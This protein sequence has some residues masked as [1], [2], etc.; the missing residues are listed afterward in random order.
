MRKGLLVTLTL[1]I[2]I[3]AAS[4]GVL[5]DSVVKKIQLKNRLIEAQKTELIILDSCLTAT[6]RAYLRQASAWN[7]RVMQLVNEIDSLKA[8]QPADQED[9]L[10]IGWPVAIAQKFVSENYEYLRIV[11]NLGTKSEGVDGILYKDQHPV[12]P[13]HLE[14]MTATLETPWGTMYWYGNNPKQEWSLV[15]WHVIPKEIY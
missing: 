11:N 4:C 13:E 15:G 7:M 3:G 8:E 9:T 1:F 2:I 5:M 6:N 14:D 12:T 10:M